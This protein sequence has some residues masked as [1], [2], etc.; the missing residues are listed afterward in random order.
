MKTLFCDLETYSDID[1]KN[2]TYAYCE[3]VSILLF[4]YA[5]DDKPAKVWDLTTGDPIPP[6]LAEGLADP[7]VRLVW[8]NGANFDRTV[9]MKAKNFRCELP[10]ERIDDTMVMAYSHGLP[11]A[12]GDLCEI[13]KLPTDKAKDKHGRLLIQ[14]FC[15]L[16]HSKRRDRTTDPEDWEHF[17]EYARLDVEAMREIW[18]KLPRWNWREYDRRLFAVDRCINDRGMLIDVDLAQA[19]VDLS[20]MLRVRNDARASELTDGALA[21]ANQRDALIGYIRDTYGIDLKDA[22]K[23]TIEAM[24]NREGLPESVKDLL[25]V[26]LSS[27]KASVSKYKKLIAATSPDHRLRGCLQFRGATRTGRFAGRTFQPQNLPR[28]SLKQEVIDLGIIGLKDGWGDLVAEPTRL[29]SAALRGVITAPEGRQLVVADLSN[30][31]GRVLAWLAGEEWKLDAFRA[32]DAGTGHDLY[33]LTYGRTFGVDPASVTKQ[34]RQIGK[35]EE[36]ALG[37]RGGVGAFLTFASAYGVDLDELAGHVKSAI[38][39]AVWNEAADAYEWFEKKKLTHGLAKETFIALDAIKRGWRASHPA[40]SKFWEDLETAALMAINYG[41]T[42]TVGRLTF[43]RK[44]SWLRMRLPSGR[45]VCYPA[46]KDATQ[47]DGL[48]VVSYLGTNQITHKWGRIN[49]HG[50]KLAENATQAVALDVLAESMPRI[51]AAGFQIVL[52]IHDEFIT[53]AGFDKTADDLARLM[54]VTPPWGAGLP[55]NAAGFTA[56]RYRKD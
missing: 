37:Y 7:S 50:G 42:T 48:G 16:Y 54:T 27:A 49:T 41:Q 1:I 14:K 8:H 51:E 32:A 36:L 28:P 11:G 29:M 23:S 38:S 31:E 10:I 46:A 17:K 15:R 6:E 22:R 30:I 2:G 9:L 35:V 56:D 34:Q 24:L 20:A 25:A 33:K 12:L 19:C 47:D 4:A 13:F 3:D 45:Y 39:P 43:D 55:L 52:S 44:D 5:V 40:I 21:S 53:E 26:R 18:R